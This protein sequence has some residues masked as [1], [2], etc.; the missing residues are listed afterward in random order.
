MRERKLI[1]QNIN[2]IYRERDK[3][4]VF[5]I[6]FSFV[7]W[8]SI[9]CV[10][11]KTTRKCQQFWWHLGSENRSHTHRYCKGQLQKLYLFPLEELCVLYFCIHSRLSCQEFSSIM[12]PNVRF[13]HLWND[14]SQLVPTAS[15]SECLM[16]SHKENDSLFY[17]FVSW[18][19]FY[20]SWL[21]MIPIS[22]MG[23]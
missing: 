7:Q 20:T 3:G 5:C 8:P 19:S 21:I 10:A 12:G 22:L 6:F 14:W 18:P 4:A 11:K 9:T 16:L 2:F 13:Y 17:S 15:M 1:S 23:N